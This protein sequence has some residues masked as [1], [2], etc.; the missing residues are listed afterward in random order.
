[1]PRVYSR[2]TRKG[3]KRG[4]GGEGGKSRKRGKGGKSRKRGKSG[5]SRRR[6]GGP[7]MS[8][9]IQFSDNSTV[10][11]IESVFPTTN[12]LR[13]AH[14]KKDMNNKMGKISHLMMIGKPPG[15]RC[16]DEE[17]AYDP[18][19]HDV[20][21]VP[22]PNSAVATNKPR[23]ESPF[24]TID[25]L[26]RSSEQ[27]KKDL[28]SDPNVEDQVKKLSDV[29]TK[30]RMT[31]NEKTPEQNWEKLI[32]TNTSN[33]GQ[34]NSLIGGQSGSRSRKGHTRK[35][36]T[37]KSRSSGKARKTRKSRSSGKARKTRKSRRPRRKS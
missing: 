24:P 5:K 1:M 20:Q 34:T 16:W 9:Q 19:K 33:S 6:G 2:R 30:I 8:K 10:P 3:G 15:P 7:V 35:K 29:V 25:Q 22:T 18:L 11:C 12:Q 26:S 23:Q 27:H 14:D 13:Y 37:R 17:S 21:R 36:R 32:D 28:Q 31:Y 4:E